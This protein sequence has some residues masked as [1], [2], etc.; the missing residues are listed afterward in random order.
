MYNRENM[1]CEKEKLLLKFILSEMKEKGFPPTIREM[2]GVINVKSLRGVTYHLDE[3]QKKNYI[4]R[5]RL[6]RGITILPRAFALS[7][8]DSLSD[9][10]ISIPIIG[11]VAAGN[12][13][14]TY[15][16]FSE[17]ISVPCSIAR[18]KKDYYAL[19]VGGDSMIGDNIMDKDIVV[20]KKQNYAN[21]GQI[22]VAVINEEATIKRFYKEKKCFRLQ[23][24]NPEFEPIYVKEL[25]INGVMV[26]L[27]RNFI[28]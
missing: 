9:A 26:G 14:Y 15:E 24:S 28:N 27:I 1:L 18:N 13:I 23:P 25:I 3:L 4:H 8:D 2:R 16:N 20:I 6:S 21:D 7:D 11:K 5:E 22:V 12:P 10:A 17:L 19:Q